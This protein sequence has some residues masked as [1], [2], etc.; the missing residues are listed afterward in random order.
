M[1]PVGAISV[2]LALVLAAFVVALV[3]ILAGAKDA[4]RTQ[5]ALRKG[6]VDDSLIDLMAWLDRKVIKNLL[7]WADRKSFH[8]HH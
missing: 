1:N 5:D 4:T 6:H 3:G 2:H 7:A 8:A